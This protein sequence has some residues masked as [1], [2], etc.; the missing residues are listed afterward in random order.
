MCVCL[1]VRERLHA[2]A[3]ATTGSPDT[4]SAPP[5]PT[6]T[7]LPPP[8]MPH[9]T[10]FT[11]QLPTVHSVVSFAD[12]QHGHDESNTDIQND[13]DVPHAFEPDSSDQDNLKHS[14]GLETDNMHSV[15]PSER[16]TCQQSH[17][18]TAQVQVLRSLAFSQGSVGDADRAA[19]GT[20][21][22]PS[23]NGVHAGARPLHGRAES[24]KQLGTEADTA[25]V[26]GQ[27]ACDSATAHHATH[28]FAAAAASHAT[29]AL[30]QPSSA[31]AVPDPRVP[32][33]LTHHGRV[34]ENWGAVSPLDAHMVSDSACDTLERLHLV[35]QSCEFHAGLSV[36]HACQRGRVAGDDRD[37]ICACA[38]VCA[39]SIARLQPPGRGS[40]QPQHSTR[41]S[42]LRRPQHAPQVSA[43]R[44]AQTAALQHHPQQQPNQPSMYPFKHVPKHRRPCTKWTRQSIVI[45]A[46]QCATT[47]C[48][49]G[50]CAAG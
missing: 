3:A 40:P 19:M 49:A 9:T 5:S 16:L 30:S 50:Q 34:L 22:A 31:R 13:N 17:G 45:A 1:Q 4:F 26:V 21:M 12:S 28:T 44:A 43:A 8:P 38:Y 46:Q 23:G 25:S 29:T 42:G 6:H 41:A 32:T 24:T 47:L 39:G 37:W 20:C 7:P 35:C 36:M 33:T 15:G 10:P 18:L 11:N 2:I 27:S 14:A 48:A